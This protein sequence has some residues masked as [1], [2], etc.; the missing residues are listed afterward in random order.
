M[1]P[2]AWGPRAVGSRDGAGWVVFPQGQSVTVLQD[3]EFGDERVVM[4]N[5]VSVLDDLLCRWRWS[6]LCYIHHHN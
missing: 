2:L 3:G 4:Y 5:S 1:I 6:I